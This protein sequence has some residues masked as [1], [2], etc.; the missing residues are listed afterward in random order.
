MCRNRRLLSYSPRTTRS[1]CARICCARAPSTRSV[2][3]V[4]ARART[5][6]VGVVDR[7]ALLLDGVDEVDR[8]ALDVGGAHPVNGQVDAAELGGQIAVE[9]SIIEEEVV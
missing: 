1:W 4:P 6:R 3:R 5:R 9:G 2:E 8:R 7:E